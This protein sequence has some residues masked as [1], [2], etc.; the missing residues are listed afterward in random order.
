MQLARVGLRRSLF[1][2][3]FCCMPVL[4]VVGLWSG[5]QALA[6]ESS[7][8]FHGVWTAT[9]GAGQTLR[10]TWT[11]QSSARGPNRVSGSWT[12]FS[13]ASEIVLQGTWSAQKTVGGWHG[14]WTARTSNGGSF[15][16]T[17]NADLAVFSGK[18]LEQMLKRA[19]D[20]QVAGSWRSGRYAGNWW[21]EGSVSKGGPR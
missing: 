13:E 9:A 8:A 3:H 1:S 15:S 21:L 20:K 18:T 10:G 16:G 11:G 2:L 4:L 19:T 12:L 5:S 14:I 6:Q 7:A 17:W